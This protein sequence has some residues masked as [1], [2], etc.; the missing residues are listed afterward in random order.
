MSEM[1]EPVT[2]TI[3]IPVSE[4]V[5]TKVVKIGS[6]IKEEQRTALSA[7]LKENVDMFTWKHVDMVGIIP[8]II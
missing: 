3:F 1:V 4:T 6:K 5:P 2:D 7:F 8:E